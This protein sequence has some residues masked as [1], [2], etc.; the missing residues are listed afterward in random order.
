MATVAHPDTPR[1]RGDHDAPHMSPVTPAEDVRSI[2]INRVSWGAVFAGAALGLVAQLILN[3][4][5]VGV[6]AS[7]L[8]IAAGDSPDAATFSLGA[9]IWWTVSGI[10]AAF[11]G[12]FAA[13]RLSGQPKESSAGWHGFVSWAVTTLVVFYLVTSA[14]GA[15]IGGAFSTLGSALG[16]AGRVAATAAET[17]APALANANDPFAAIERQVRGGG[18][19]AAAMD[20][21]VASLR[22]ALAGDGAQA[23]QARDRA[24]EALAQ[25][26]GIPV[27]EARSRIA[28]YEQQYRQAV[29]SAKAQATQAADTAAD[30]VSRAALFGALALIL[31]A[32]AAWFGGRAGTVDPTMTVGAIGRRA[33][34]PRST[35][36]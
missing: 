19:P 7:T 30:A 9:A 8:D 5:G 22:A 11:I 36:G 25:A 31:G 28:Q 13:G 34:E 18:D 14:A 27:E 15:L 29:E 23:Q 33:E 20:A 21:A 4:L 3:M 24:A 16:G 10:I 17:A 1:A 26:Q 35:L 12:G 2:L 32:I 6:G